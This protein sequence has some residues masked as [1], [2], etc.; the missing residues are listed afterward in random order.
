ML[1]RGVTWSAPLICPVGVYISC[2]GRVR[3]TAQQP[4][5]ASRARV[6]AHPAGPRFDPGQR[7]G[8]SLRARPPAFAFAG[9][10]YRYLSV[11]HMYC[12]PTWKQQFVVLLLLCVKVVGRRAPGGVCWQEAALTQQ[13]AHWGVVS[14][15]W[16]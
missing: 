8:F 2:S 9:S 5:V 6:R 11:E 16:C 4:L 7:Q 13:G 3:H 14:H 1:S 15:H 12:T 10:R